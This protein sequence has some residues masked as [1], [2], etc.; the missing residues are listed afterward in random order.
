MRIVL[1]PSETKTPGGLDSSHLEWEQLA[2]P[3]LTSVRQAIAEDLVALSLDPDATKKALGLGAKGDEWIVANRELLSSPVMPAIHRYTGVLF[4]ALDIS[5]LDAAAS[6]H[7]AESL[8]LFS[9]LFGPLRAMNPIPRY[10]LSFDSKLPGESLKSRWQPHAEQIWADDFTIDLRSEGYRA[11]APLPEGTGVFIRVVKDLDRGA[12]VGHANKATKGKMVRDLLT[13]NAHIDS[14]GKLLDWGG[15]HGWHF[16][17]V[18]DNA[19][20]LYLVV[21]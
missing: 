12:A 17:E 21:G 1:P 19:G 9:A 11:L 10:R 8:W 3:D 2:L 13:S 7:A 18:P 20:E 15:A 5:G 16:A 4:D 14:A 6:A